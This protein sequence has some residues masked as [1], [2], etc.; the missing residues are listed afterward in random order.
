MRF[1][2]YLFVI[3]SLVSFHSMMAVDSLPV[4]SESMDQNDWKHFA[5]IGCG[6]YPIPEELKKYISPTLDLANSLNV[7]CKDQ[8]G[9]SSEAKQQFEMLF[10]EKKDWSHYPKETSVLAQ[11][12]S[13]VAVSILLN[14][15]QALEINPELYPKITGGLS[16]F[17]GKNFFKIVHYDAT[18]NLPGILWHKDIRW[19]TVLFI[20]QEGLQGKVD[21]KVIDIGPLEGYFVVNLGVFF[22]A[23]INDQEKLKAFEHQV[24]QVK[25]DRVSFG[26]FCAGDYPEKG[27][28]QL[29]GEELSWKNPEEMKAF[30]VEDKSQSFMA[31]PNIIFANSNGKN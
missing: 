15:L 6:Y 22:E 26:I 14:V 28:Y 29:N 11:G 7:S 30:L 4:L 23:F 21:G 27:F 5:K 31:S 19:V 13:E 9:Y 20:N 17:E 12:M 24:Q 16:N 8:Y 3:F 2:K 10:L 18:K 25:K 1:S